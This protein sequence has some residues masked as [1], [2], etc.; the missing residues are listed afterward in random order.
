MSRID[1]TTHKF[2]VLMCLGL[3]LIT[4]V[5]GKTFAD[6]MHS[7]AMLSFQGFD[8][9][10]GVIYDGIQEIPEA[11]AESPD[12]VRLEFVDEESEEEPPVY[13]RFT[14]VV[15]FQL[16]Y[17]AQHEMIILSPVNGLS[18]AVFEELPFETVDIPPIEDI[19]LTSDVLQIPLGLQ[20]VIL[21]WTADDHFFKIGNF[22]Y[23]E[24]NLA[25]DYESI[26]PHPIVEVPLPEWTPGPEVTVTPEITPVPEVT[27]VAPEVTPVPEPSTSMLFGMGLLVFIGL[28]FKTKSL[29]TFKN[30]ARYFKHIFLLVI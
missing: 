20:C 1:C 18:I 29:A 21:L 12:M 19:Q 26:A 2:I 9:E 28:S 11:E 4:H 17:N 27:P 13:Y 14:G 15:D 22:T 25:F 16:H 30:L 7:G 10:Q 8:A 6:P 3:A 5:A 23:T 24:P